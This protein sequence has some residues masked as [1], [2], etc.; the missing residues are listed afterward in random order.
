MLI[1]FLLV[2]NLALQCAIKKVQENHVRMEF[3][4]RFQVL[5]FADDVNLLGENINNTK[6]IQKLCKSLV[7]RL[8]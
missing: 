2:L 4:G 7:R 6:K 8:V 1:G 3:N 5:F